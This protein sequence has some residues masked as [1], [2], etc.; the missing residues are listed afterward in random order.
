MT[1]AAR[2]SP[3]QSTEEELS[4]KPGPA[5]RCWAGSDYA[6]GSVC[7]FAPTC[8]PIVPQLE[9]L[10]GRQAVARELDRPQ[11]GAE[12]GLGCVNVDG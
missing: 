6:P 3:S 7:A 8:V 4:E 2:E 11:L 10:I 12:D 9:L 5:R 1:A